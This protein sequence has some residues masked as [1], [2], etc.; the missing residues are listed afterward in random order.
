MR[1][2]TSSLI[3]QREDIHGESSYFKQVLKF[4]FKYA[5]TKHKQ[6]YRGTRVLFF[7]CGTNRHILITIING[8]LYRLQNA[9]GKSRRK[10]RTK[11]ATIADDYY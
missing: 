7:T 6:V 9:G 8:N 1:V 10:I 5:Y 11:S 2:E 3:W 4:L